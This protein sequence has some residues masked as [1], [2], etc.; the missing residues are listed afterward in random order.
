MRNWPRYAALMRRMLIIICVVSG[1]GLLPEGAQLNPSGQ[2]P[3]V[4]PSSGG[5]AQRPQARPDTPDVP[6]PAMQNGAFGRTIA[7]LGNATE[8]GL[9]LKTPL[10][11]VERSGSVTYAATGQSVAL[12]LI[13]ID[14]PRTAGSRISLGAMQALGA[15]LTDLIELDVFGF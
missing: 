2:N 3:A 14:G 9:W 5:I 7:S 6:I 13:P 15:P 1:C 11:P 8:P 4:D 10:T 12:T